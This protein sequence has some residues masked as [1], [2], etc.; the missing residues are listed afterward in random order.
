MKKIVIM[1]LLIMGVN[2]H[3][4][5]EADGKDILLF[6]MMNIALNKDTIEQIKVKMPPTF[7]VVLKEGVAMCKKMATHTIWEQFGNQEISFLGNRVIMSGNYNAS[8][9]AGIDY[10]ISKVVSN[11][12][13]PL[14]KKLEQ[15]DVRVTIPWAIVRGYAAVSIAYFI[16]SS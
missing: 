9:A 6:T 3:S 16:T 15:D 2:T 12:P 14:I 4:V 13:W 10:G 7:Q 8:L 11:I 1:F 5:G